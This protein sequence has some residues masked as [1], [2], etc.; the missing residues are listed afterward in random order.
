M[1]AALADGAGFVYT[2]RKTKGHPMLRFAITLV[3]LVGLIRIGS[4]GEDV[5]SLARSALSPLPLSA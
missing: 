2:R 4:T 1:L 3:A 5:R